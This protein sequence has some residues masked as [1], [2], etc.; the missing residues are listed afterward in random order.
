MKTLPRLQFSIFGLM[1]LTFEVAV[2]VSPL[3][4]VVR[5]MRGET[6]YRAV[7]VLMAVALPMLVMILVSALYQLSRWLKRRQSK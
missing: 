4:Y 2:A 7:A 1:V 3:Y 6:G 5:A